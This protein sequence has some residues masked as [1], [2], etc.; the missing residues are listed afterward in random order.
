MQFALTPP[1]TFSSFLV[2]KRTR[3]AEPKQ[4]SLYLN[5][6]GDK[7]MHR[8]CSPCRMTGL[9]MQLNLF[10]V[11]S[12]GVTRRAPA[13]PA[14]PAYRQAGGRQVTNYFTKRITPTN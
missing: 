12:F 1:S 2:S 3:N 5:S 14:Y 10:T 8:T 6:N 4:I 11:R 7:S 9:A 13:Y